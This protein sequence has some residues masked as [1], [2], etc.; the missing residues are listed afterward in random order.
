MTSEDPSAVAAELA[1]TRAALKAAREEL[2]AVR[3][4]ENKLLDTLKGQAS[5]LSGTSERASDVRRF[6][7][8][9][10]LFV[11]VSLAAWQVYL[12]FQLRTLLT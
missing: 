11:M 10:M 5:A 12:T 1:S 3:Q 8:Y 9:L 4:R 2:E 7:E 6:T